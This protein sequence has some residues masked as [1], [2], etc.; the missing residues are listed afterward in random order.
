MQRTYD[1]YF[2]SNGY[3]DRYP[4]PN[5]ATLNY[6]L[7]NGAREASS[8][9]DFGCG[10]GRYSL[11][12]LARCKARLTGYDISASS[13]Q[14]FSESLWRS[15]LRE[16]VA[17]VH[18]DLFALAEQGPYD[19]ILMLFG[20]LSHVG[21]RAARIRM[22]SV[23]R[24]LIRAEGRLIVSVPSAFRRRPTDLAKW[25]L[26]RRFGLARAPQDEPRNIYFTRRVNG[27]RVRFFYHL[28]TRVELENELAEAG[29]RVL[30][31]EAESFFPEQWVTRSAF[32]RRI[33]AW[34]SRWAPAT[35]GYGI[36]AL[37]VAL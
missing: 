9:L 16:R 10:N 20:V 5:A 6:I 19:M 33:D 22:L 30:H 18:D 8:I 25:S 35:F 3:R 12:L 11:E 29:F 1:W 15:V 26:A 34:F 24:K 14:E 17:L 21:D 4:R 32:V 37:A 13:L 28:Y 31:C 27:C 2:M 7:A 36:R 23:L